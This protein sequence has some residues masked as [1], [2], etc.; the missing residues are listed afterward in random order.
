MKDTVNIL[1]VN[2]PRINVNDTLSII[3]ERIKREITELFHVITV[4]PEIVLNYKKDENLKKI[5]DEAGLI[6]ADGVGII[7]ASKWKRDPLPERVTGCDVLIKLLEKGN[8]RKWSFY[9][10]GAAEE[11]SEKAYECITKDYPNVN[12]VG[13][14]NGFYNK[15]EEKE[16]IKNIEQLKPDILVVALGA[17]RAEKWIYDNKNML[18]AKVAIGVGGSLDIISGTVKRAPKVWQKMNLEW[19]YRL[20]KQPWRWKRQLVLPVF[21]FKALVDAVKSR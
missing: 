6:T 7:M 2:F 16:I 15:E 21:A 4:N 12:I 1:G 20:I 17:P 10:F 13:R 5:I 3:E 11:V 8:D 14:H 18:G 9:L 19:L